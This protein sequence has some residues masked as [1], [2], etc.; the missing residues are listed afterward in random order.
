[1]ERHVGLA[2]RSEIERLVPLH[3]GRVQGSRAGHHVAVD[4]R[5][6][7]ALEQ[8]ARCAHSESD[9]ACPHHLI[10]QQVVC[11][12]CRQ[13]GDRGRPRHRVQGNRLCPI[14]GSCPTRAGRSGAGGHHQ[15][16]RAAVDVLPVIVIVTGPAAGRRVVVSKMV[17]GEASGSLRRALANQ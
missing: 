11:P 8:C 5:P 12:R 4:L 9:R 3:C 17:I 7:L 16:M 2:G 10:E 1:M 13:Q 15:L 14:P 6:G